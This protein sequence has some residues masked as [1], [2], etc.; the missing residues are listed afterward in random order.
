VNLIAD[1]FAITVR[2]ALALVLALGLVALAVY[3]AA[4]RIG[5]IF[6]RE[7]L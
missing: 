7:A 5:Q 6:N 3:A 2:T 1:A 4:D